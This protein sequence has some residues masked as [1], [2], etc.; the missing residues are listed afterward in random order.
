MHEGGYGSKV[1]GF[2]S[3]PFNEVL[4]L[5]TNIFWWYKPLIYGGLSHI[6]FFR[7]LSFGAYVSLL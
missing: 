5:T 4:S 3:G 1:M 6:Y 2:Y 7:E